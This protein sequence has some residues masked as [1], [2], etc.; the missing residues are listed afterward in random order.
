[1]LSEDE[2]L[3]LE[4]INNQPDEVCKMQMSK[5]NAPGF[6]NERIESMRIKGFIDR[7]IGYYNNQLVG[8][9]RAS[10]LGNAMLSEIH[11]KRH[12]GAENKSEHRKN[13][14]FQILLVVL[15]VVLTL[16]AEHFSE[17]VKLIVG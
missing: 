3:F 14:I 16:L 17:I 15:G 2:Q 5:M 11:E 6:T 4:W 1:M 7:G 9:Y 13:R 8:M 12:K 10:D